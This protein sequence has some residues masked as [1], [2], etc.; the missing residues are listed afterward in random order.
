MEDIAH[1]TTVCELAARQAGRV[2]LDWLGRAQVTAKAPADLVTEA[3]FAAQ[4][5]IRDIIERE[6]PTH[7]FLG[8][9]DD[10]STA[11]NSDSPYRWLVDPLDGTTNYVHGLPYFCVSV[12]V[13]HL[14]KVVAGVV[15]DPV[16][17]DCFRA[18]AGQG[19]YRGAQRIQVSDV[20]RLSDALVVTGFGPRPDRDSAEVRR[21]LAIIGACQAVRRMG[22]AALNMCHLAAGHFDAYWAS[23]VK[24]WDVAAGLLIIR[25][26]GGLVTGLDGGDFDLAKPRLLAA[27][28]P[29]LH[30]EVLRLFDGVTDD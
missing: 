17:D 20:R 13:E 24:T 4:Q 5:R 29:Q 8:E 22:A 14:G 23:S 15:F 28:T 11:A 19:A 25:E 6:F 16:H 21:F 1:F 10:A 27:A 12:A 9:E 18:G 7:N 30:E 2:L 3:D 26:A